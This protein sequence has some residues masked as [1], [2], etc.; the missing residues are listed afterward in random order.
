MSAYRF[1]R[2]FTGFRNLKHYKSF[3]TPQVNGIYKSRLRYLK[4]AIQMRREEMTN[5]I[6]Q[7]AM[8]QRRDELQTR[9]DELSQEQTQIQRELQAISLYL[10]ALKGVLP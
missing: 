6:S 7:E 4:R 3:F 8:I 2:A 9:L 10:D 5:S 1:G